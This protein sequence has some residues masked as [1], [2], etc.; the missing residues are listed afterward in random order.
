M[1]IQ[2]EVNNLNN[3]ILNSIN[4]DGITSPF[5]KTE[6]KMHM[7]CIYSCGSSCSNACTHDCQGGCQ[8]GCYMG[9]YAG[10]NKPW[11]HQK[12]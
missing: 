11:H 1:N 4:L 10:C 7:G 3:T 6:N 12:H 2:T 5:N 8:G 9:C